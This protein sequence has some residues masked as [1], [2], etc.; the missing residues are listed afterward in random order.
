MRRSLR[1][2]TLIELL[3]VVALVA[4]VAGLALPRLGI[5]GDRRILAEAEQ[6][7]ASLE[8]TRQRAAV[9]GIPHRLVVDLERQAY[10]IEAWQEAPPEPGSAAGSAAG[11]TQPWHPADRDWSDVRNL[12]MAAPREADRTWRP[13]PGSLGADTP[14]P[15]GM[16]ILGVE[17]PEGI[18]EAGRV[19]LTFGADGS[20][21]ATRI[22]LADEDGNQITLESAPLADAVRLAWGGLRERPH[23]G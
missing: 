5:G 6:L 19:E 3:A 12:P 8:F 11:E 4:L 13:I 23:G 7:A 9:T 16:A 1:G 14:I 18:A 2:F 22:E 10:R 17:T 21:D 15:V 20:G